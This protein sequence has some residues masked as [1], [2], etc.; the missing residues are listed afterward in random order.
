MKACRAARSP[1]SRTCSKN[2]CALSATVRTL[3]AHRARDVHQQRDVER[4][5]GQRLGALQPQLAAP[6]AQPEVGPPQAVGRAA[7]GVDD[8]QVELGQPHVDLLDARPEEH[9]VLGGVAAGQRSA[10]RQVVGAGGQA[11]GQRAAPRRRRERRGGPPAVQALDAVDGRAQREAESHRHVAA[12]RS[13]E[14]GVEGALLGLDP[15][16]VAGQG[17]A[18]GVQGDGDRQ[19]APAGAVDGDGVGRIVVDSQRTAVEAELHRVDGTSG[20]GGV[21]T[22]PAAALGRGGQQLDAGEGGQDDD[23]RPGQVR[24]AAGPPRRRRRRLLGRRHLELAPIGEQRP[25]V[26]VDGAQVEGVGAGP[27][28]A[29]ELQRHLRPGMGAGDVVHDLEAVGQTRAAVDVA[30]DGHPVEELAR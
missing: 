8:R 30:G 2:R 27:Q 18:L 22:H 14:A 26:T 3:A 11:L 15:A 5:V 10:H 13:L 28:P 23:V 1:G 20:G 7:L 16:L 29:M 21:Q 25:A 19:A 6:V 4:Q 24:V 12:H 17:T 9:H